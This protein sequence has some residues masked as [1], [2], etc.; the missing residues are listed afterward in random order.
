MRLKRVSCVEHALQRPSVAS[1]FGA[2]GGPASTHDCPEEMESTLVA[3]VCVVK[4]RVWGCAMFL[5]FLLYQHGL[6][7][8]LNTSA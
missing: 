2:S 7:L 8:S 3:V 4:W 6:T 1:H 5:I